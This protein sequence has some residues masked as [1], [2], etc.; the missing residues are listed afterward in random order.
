MNFQDFLDKITE[1]FL[2]E[3]QPHVTGEIEFRT[4][5]TWDSL[6]GMAILTIIEDDYG[7]SI[8]VEDFKNLKT[9]EEIFSYVSNNTDDK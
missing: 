8:P 4:L 1:Q 2:E 9:I 3:D 6:T 7:V 5:S